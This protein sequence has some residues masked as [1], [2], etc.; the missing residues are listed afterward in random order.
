MF[1]VASYY[2][3]H[4]A[5][6][7]SLLGYGVCLG[8]TH[9]SAALLLG[10]AVEHEEGRAKEAVNGIWNTM[11]EA[12]GSLGFLLGG[13]LAEDYARQLR[14]FGT[15]TCFCAFCAVTM[16]MMGGFRDERLTP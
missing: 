7:V 4:V 15:Y 14:L 3:H 6:W 10:D 12:G 11:W 13:F 16:L 2:H 8:V 9:T 5:L 1:L